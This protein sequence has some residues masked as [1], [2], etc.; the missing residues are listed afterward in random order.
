MLWFS[1]ILGAHVDVIEEPA[2]SP[3]VQHE[4]DLD[5]VRAF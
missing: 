3:R 2:S 1:E 5:R 4:I